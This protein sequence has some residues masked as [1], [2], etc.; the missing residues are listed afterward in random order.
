MI[1]S[2]DCLSGEFT[3]IVV[4]DIDYLSLFSR[5]IIVIYDKFSFDLDF[6]VLEG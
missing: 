5:E 2:D 4:V 1:S 3:K 6:L